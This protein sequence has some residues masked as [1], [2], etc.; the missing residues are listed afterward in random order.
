[1]KIEFL[2]E[3]QLEFDEAIEYYDNESTGLGNAFLEEV[4]NTIDRITKFPEAWHP[5]SGNIRRCQ[6]R[7][8]PFGVI[9]IKIENLILVISISHLHRKPNHW[10]DRIK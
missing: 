3:A 1:M 6:T 2:E 9:Y 7:R 8:F 10:Q 4:L 5:L